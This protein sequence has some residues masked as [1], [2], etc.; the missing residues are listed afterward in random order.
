MGCAWSV[1]GIDQREMRETEAA[2]CLI[3][4]SDKSE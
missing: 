2:D 1:V 4:S 3:G